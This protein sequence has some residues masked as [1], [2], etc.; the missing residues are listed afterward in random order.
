MS[1]VLPD[2][3][4][5]VKCPGGKRRLAAQI[6]ERMPAQI[7]RYVEPFLGG[8]A[9]FF[10]LAN[11]SRLHKTELILLGDRD[12]DLIKL[13]EA[14]RTDPK[15]LWRNALRVSQRIMSTISYE[16]ERQLWNE[17]PRCRTPARHLALRYNGYNGLW[18]VARKGTMNV[19]WCKEL[20]D[21]IPPLERYEA[22]SWA[23]KNTHLVARNFPA[24][25]EGGWNG[26]PIMRPGTVVYI[27]PPYVG[28]WTNYTKHGFSTAEQIELMQ[29]C[30]AWSQMGAHVIYS[31]SGKEEARE[32]L[33]AHW[34]DGIVHTTDARR[35]INRDGSGRGNVAELVVTS[36]MK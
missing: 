2:A 14:V 26:K 13:Y 28:G 8:G 30:S 33:A 22:A 19:A 1:S 23:L 17:V 36:C 34:P 10:E 24:Y 6:I 7:E 3:Q 5:F 12:E 18:R 16:H 9:V 25:T 29:C 32:L 35:S 4:P 11:Q 31:Q 20:G 21:R 15:A 27:D